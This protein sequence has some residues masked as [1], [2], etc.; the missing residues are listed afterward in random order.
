MKGDRA[1]LLYPVGLDFV[2]AFFGCLYSGVIAVPAPPPDASRLSRMWARVRAIIKDAQPAIVL[3]TSTVFSQIEQAVAQAP[4]LR[5]LE[6]LTTDDIAIDLA[7]GWREAAISSDTLVLLQYTSGSTSAPRGVMVNHKNL[8]HNSNYIRHAWTYTPESI[9]AIWVPNFHDD[10]LVHGTVQPIFSGF[11]C[12]QMPPASLV[13]RP[14][15]WLNAI[16]KY[17]VTHSG[18]PNFAYSLCVRKVS[19]QQRDALD[20]SSWTMAYNAAEPIRKETLQQFVKAFE[21]CGF[22]WRTFYPA[23]GLAES[24]LLV[25]TGR[26]TERPLFCALDA[27]ALEYS[28]RVAP[29]PEN[30]PGARTLVGCGRP[31]LEMNI[32]IVNPETM[33]RCAPD[34]VGEIWLSDASVAQGYWN[35]PEETARTFQ[36][37]LKDS[38]EGPFL[39][40][41][42]LGFVKDGELFIAGRIK[43]LIIIRGR[44]LYPQDIELTVEHSDPS[45]RPGCGAAFSVDSDGEERLVIVQEVNKPEGVSLDHVVEK[46]CQAVATEH[47]VQA[48]CVALIRGGT[49]LKTSSGKIQRHACRAEFLAGR[50]DQVKLWS[51]ADVIEPG[52]GPAPAVGSEKQRRPLVAIEDQTRQPASRPQSD[53]S[54]GRADAIINWLRRYGRERI[55]SRLIDER[56]CIQPHIVLDL[57]NQGILGMQV[58]QSHGGI[59]LS[60]RDTLRILEQLGAIN[61]TLASFVSGNNALGIRPILRY[62]SEG[63][64]DD[65]LPILAKGRELAAFALTEPGAGSNPRAISSTATAE[66]KETWRLRGVKVWSGTAAWAGLINVFAKVANH[67]DEPDSITGFALRQGTPGL[68]I[69]PEAITMGVRGMVQNSIYLDDVRVG[70]SDLLGGI[71]QGMQ[72]AQ[73]AIM[74]A[75][76]ALGAVSVGG[77]KRCAQLMLRYAGR[78]S[79]ATGRLLD[80]PVTVAKL[81]DLT[82]RAA[83][84]EALV[85]RIAWLT[86]GGRSLPPEAYMACKIAGS[87]FLWQAAD[88]LV[89]LLGGRGYVETN[90]APQILRDARLF[91]I[92]EGP[93]EALNMFLGTSVTHGREDLYKFIADGLGSPDI[94]G[95]LERAARQVADRFSGTASPFQSRSDALRWVYASNGELGVY[96]LL[97]AAVE[98]ALTQ[99]PSA[100]LHRAAAWARHRFETTLDRIIH[101]TQVDSGLLN[102]DEITQTISAYADH[103]NDIEQS[104]AG[105]DNALDDLLRRD[106]S[107][108]P[109]AFSPQAAVSAAES[110][111]AAD[112]P[113][114]APDDEHG[115]SRLAGSYGGRPRDRGHGSSTGW[116]TRR[117]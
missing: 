99:A 97:S 94:S 105:E 43:D 12:I 90:I 115:R 117:A 52:R 51:L 83:A 110:Y 56:R 93:T 35:R 38:G 82:A 44:N 79:V 73:D 1:L 28:N 102:V 11:L 27:R 58:P 63:L 41:G 42:D 64:R 114:D 48:Y 80:N 111:P 96:A 40:T 107:S 103:I 108:T 49:I 112:A 6:W 104:L 62:A 92:F 45:L 53:A 75:R 57:G 68:R 81:S 95:S 23:F 21:P 26:Q 76:L 85:V 87:E 7:S 69:G 109:F 59:E 33:T 10:G 4:D 113:H 61:L 89:Q 39:R 84:T 71:G 25:S 32:A 34:E 3:T 20:L 13:Q 86:D 50:L 66:S 54:K 22:R 46:I 18:G 9:S 72:V 91:R 106:L 14:V 70:S 65:L 77:M 78:R 31:V 47:D 15:R 101:R 100:S 30:D 60:N 24:T 55:N 74:F 98:D 37:Y 29:A 19:Q 2:S 67:S 8:M 16:S 5:S 116:S 17:R 36:A 88:D